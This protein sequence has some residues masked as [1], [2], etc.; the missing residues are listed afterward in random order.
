MAA[1]S[2]SMSLF[3][4]LQQVVQFQLYYVLNPV[5]SN[6]WGPWV[7]TILDFILPSL[8]PLDLNL[9]VITDLLGS[10]TA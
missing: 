7:F 3:L 9:T 6:T 5:G 10:N 1:M 8:L 2:Q 4:S